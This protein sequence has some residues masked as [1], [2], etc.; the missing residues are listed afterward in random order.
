MKL[1]KIIASFQQVTPAKKKKPAPKT[2]WRVKVNGQF[3]QTFSRKTVWKQI[4]HA[5]NAI[6]QHLDALHGMQPDYW[7]TRFDS[8]KALVDLM[9]QGLLEFV[10]LP[11]DNQQL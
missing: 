11:L 9:T 6:L 10:E 4:G 3:I 7:S 2:V 1:S 5:K 8:K